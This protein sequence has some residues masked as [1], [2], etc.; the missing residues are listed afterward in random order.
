MKTQKE[1][2]DQ[3]LDA[4]NGSL[5][6]LNNLGLS[7]FPQLYEE[8]DKIEEAIWLLMNVYN[9]LLSVKGDL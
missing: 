7:N 3:A 1:T 9:S 2:I 5:A 8:D 4:V 6:N